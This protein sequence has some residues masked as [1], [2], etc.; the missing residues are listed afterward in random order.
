[1]E[2]SLATQDRIERVVITTTDPNGSPE[3]RVMA[4]LFANGLRM[5]VDVIEWNRFF[6]HLLDP[7][8][9]ALVRDG[10][11]CMVFLRYEDWDHFQEHARNPDIEPSYGMVRKKIGDLIY[12]IDCAAMRCVGRLL[13]CVLPSSEPVS[14]VS[15]LVS[16]FSEMTDHMRTS[17]AHHN[18]VSVIEL[19][20][21]RDSLPE[22]DIRPSKMADRGAL[23]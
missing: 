9:L 10:V 22:D 16:F 3:P 13:L 1:M 23:T 20:R 19:R 21:H 12:A 2:L 15:H 18:S 7:A 17:L 11:V 5:R 6:L 14:R 8:N 4:R